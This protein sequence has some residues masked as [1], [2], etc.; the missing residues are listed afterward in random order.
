MA[1]CS[2]CGRPGGKGRPAL[3]EACAE[4]SA[5][6]LLLQNPSVRQLADTAIAGVTATLDR[7][8]QQVTTRIDG[9]A[10]AAFQAFQA[11]QAAAQQAGAAAPP[12][13]AAPDARSVMGFGP[14]EEL[15]AEKVKR[16]YHELARVFHS[17]AGGHDSAMARL[18]RA[19]EEL[20]KQ[21]NTE[22]ES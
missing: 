13:A 19:R 8:F 2:S 1:K 12:P 14:D 21:F 17:D 9:Y 7:G 18:N 5:L 10:R 3:C 16:R 6:E 4:P 20:E 11:R 15:T 22:G